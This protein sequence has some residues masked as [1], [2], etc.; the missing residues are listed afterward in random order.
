MFGTSGIIFTFR[1]YTIDNLIVVRYNKN[2]TRRCGK[3]L[4]LSKN[5]INKQALLMFTN[6]NL[7]GTKKRNSRERI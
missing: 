5:L 7:T 4:Q 2:T 3:W 6:Q 1:H